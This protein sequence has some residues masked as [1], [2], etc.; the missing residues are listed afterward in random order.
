MKVYLTI[1]DHY[2]ICWFYLKTKQTKFHSI[3]DKPS[4]WEF[5]NKQ[6]VYKAWCKNHKH[7]R[8]TGPAAIWKRGD[9]CYYLNGYCFGNDKKHWERGLQKFKQKRK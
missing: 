7:H 8:E 9:F 4:V 1:D 3:N 6:W 2:E 5:K